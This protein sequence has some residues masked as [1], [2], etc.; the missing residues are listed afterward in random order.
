LRLSNQSLFKT[1][2]VSTLLGT[3]ALSG[4]HAG[5]EYVS[6]KDKNPV[7]PVPPPAFPRFYLSI[8][9]GGDVDYKSTKFISN[10]GGTLLGLPADINARYYPK[11]HDATLR[12]EFTLGYNV[13]EMFSVFGRFEYN[14]AFTSRE[15][16]G[17]VRDVN[18]LF[19][20]DPTAH[21][22]VNADL[23][24]YEAYAGKGGVRVA[25][26]IRQIPFIKPYF[27]AAVG[28][29]YVEAT[30][31]NFTINSDNNNTVANLGEARLY[32]GSWV[33]SSDARL[34]VECEITRNIAL[35]VE[36]GIGYDTKLTRARQ[37][38]GGNPRRPT[39]QDL[40]G[41]GVSQGGDR[42]YSPLTASVKVSF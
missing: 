1:L 5:T 34:G 23:S 17:N 15:N 29:K 35:N 39:V 32:R 25:L 14:H 33:F 28:G 38:S 30:S 27:S 11:V 22:D 6:S 7:A 16:I 41:T 31:A 9:G 26:P 8:G 12:G 4:L 20:A 42:L 3:C 19:G 21:Y 24:D 13:N 18:N 2:A 40:G 37:H 36:G 10:G